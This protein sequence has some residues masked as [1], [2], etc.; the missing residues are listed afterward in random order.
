MTKGRTTSDS[1]RRVQDLRRSGATQPVPGRKQRRKFDP[2]GRHTNR[3]NAK[4]AALR[5]F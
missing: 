2:V 5:E 1:V 4:R 3:S